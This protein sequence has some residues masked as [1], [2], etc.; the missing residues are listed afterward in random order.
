MMNVVGCDGKLH[1]GMHCTSMCVAEHTHVRLRAARPRCARIRHKC[2][3]SAAARACACARTGPGRGYTG[4][5]PV[6]RDCVLRQ[7]E[8]ARKLVQ[9]VDDSADLVGPECRNV[10][11]REHDRE[12]GRHGLG[13]VAHKVAGDAGGVGHHVAVADVF[14]FGA[15]RISMR[16]VGGMLL[17]LLPVRTATSAG[18][19]A[20]LLWSP[21]LPALPVPHSSL[22]LLLRSRCTLAPPKLQK[23][24]TPY[25]TRSARAA[26]SPHTRTTP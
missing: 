11:H 2:G 3:R 24:A 19:L 4:G 13:R 10:P 20:L 12:G 23:V 1:R 8:D 25:S 5:F 6:D 7:A 14:G 17:L 21:L 9:V 16:S 22:L 18:S 26:G 15:L